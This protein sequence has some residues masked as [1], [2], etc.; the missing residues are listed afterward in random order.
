MFSYKI[1]NEK[2]EILLAVSDISIVGKTFEEGE[3]IL[4]I[5]KN[6]YFENICDESEI[7]KIVKKATIINA[8]GKKIINLLLEEDIINK[9][10]VLTIGGVPHAQFV[11]MQ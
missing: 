6:F 11:S 9:E 5:D 8:V 7:R 2:K 1:W 3:M 4:N 10:N